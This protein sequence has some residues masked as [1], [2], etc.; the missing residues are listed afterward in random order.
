MSPTVAEPLSK[1]FQKHWKWGLSLASGLGEQA[2]AG[3]CSDLAGGLQAGGTSLTPGPS[4]APSAPPAVTGAPPQPPSPLVTYGDTESHLARRAP[5]PGPRS[6]QHL[7]WPGS[8]TKRSKCLLWNHT[9]NI[10]G[11]HGANRLSLWGCPGGSTQTGL[12]G[13]LTEG[14]GPRFGP[15]GRQCVDPE[16]T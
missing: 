4:G 5:A 9:E 11:T 7:G 14:S 2:Q 15:L 6:L 3:L 1:G 10:Q 13:H 8:G 16:N 12:W